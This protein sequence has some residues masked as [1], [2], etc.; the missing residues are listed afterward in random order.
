M[1]AEL[2][3]LKI[4]FD[5]ASTEEV[6]LHCPFHDDKSPSCNVNVKT[7]QFICRAADCAKGREGGD[8]VSL[9]SAI[10][11]VPRIVLLEELGT[12]YD[13]EDVRI[14][15]PKVIERWHDAIWSAKPLLQA[16][17][18]RAVTDEDIKE[19]K[20][21]ENNGRI[22]IPVR[23]DR[24]D[25]VNVRKYLP[26]ASGADKMKNMPGRGQ[27]RWFMPEQ[28]AY[29]SVMICGGEMKAVVAKR[30]LNPH[31][32]GAVSITAGERLITPDLLRRLVGKVCYV[33][34]DI[35]DAG[36]AAAQLNCRS[37]RGQ[38]SEVYDVILPLDRLKYPKGDTNDFV[39]AGGDLWALIDDEALEQWQPKETY[40]GGD[41]AEPADLHITAAA[42]A[43]YAG[44][45]VRVGGVVSMME[46]APFIVP[47]DVIVDCDRSQPFCSLCPVFN[48][49]DGE[50]T[51]GP[52]NPAV[53]EAI[54]ASKYQ[55]REAIMNGIGVP[56]ACRV[57]Q[58]TTKTHYNAEDARLAPQLELTNHA[59]DRSMTPAVCIGE[60]LELNG[61]YQFT[62]RMWPNPRT[63]QSTLL[64][65]SYSPTKDSLST[66]VAR[67]LDRLVMFRPEE[68]SVE[69]VSARLDRLYDDIENNVTRVRQRRTLHLAVDLAYHSPLH[70]S[71]DDRII[72]GWTEVLIL[73]DTSQ[74]KSE[75][76]CG[77]GRPG[78]LLMHY[79]IGEK[80]ECKNATAAGLLG[81]VQSSGGKF[82]VSWGA[83]VAHDRRLLILDEFNGISVEGIAKLTDMRSS[84]VAELPKIERRKAL[85]R[86]RIVAIANSRS[87]RPMSAFPFGIDALMELMGSPQDLRRFDLAMI[88]AADE[89]DST[90]INR[91][92]EEWPEIEHVHTT[93]LCRSLI[94]WAWTRRPEQATFHREAV[95]AT[96]DGTNRLCE[97]YSDDVPLVDRGSTRHKLARLSAA[98]A[99]R[100]FSTTDDMESVLVRPCHVQYIEQLIDSEYSKPSVGYA[101]Y[102]QAV[103]ATTSIVNIEQIIA[104]LAALPYPRETVT[105]MLRTERIE[106]QDVQDWSGWDA[107]EA[108]NLMSLLVRSHALIRDGRHYK[109]SGEFIGLLKH[110]LENG[111]LE[112]PKHVKPAPEE[113]F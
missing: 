28:L 10:L 101:R 64:I 58:T 40:V 75:V 55:L 48:K 90:V 56:L 74:G 45:R 52:E 69:G 17:Y 19:L 76:A 70:L 66:Y 35:D 11:R 12:R 33:Q 22:M 25:V 50:F 27:A 86:C 34:M 105:S 30:Q 113:K 14:V 81:G 44:R 100:T 84:G 79:G 99:A 94:L 97:K 6:K 68:W 16:L 98:L 89:V 29:E 36:R 59:S 53:L 60:G 87:R 46:T 109:K 42:N 72:K 82:F 15:D 88:L 47:K 57:C 49:A 103:K 43:R 78:G 2:E 61:A 83:W 37:L 39:K 112:K 54:S 63:Q 110:A 85:A 92:R 104:N 67:D 106:P 8:F 5:W 1:L 108:K 95:K 26:G 32:V 21:G 102:S 96:Y 77:S 62:G 65:S 7:G 107:V 18:D 38:A 24:G 23:N 51:I 31:G 80:I 4:E 91:R 73:G 71:F 111:C 20:L 41:D 3:R 13:L 93:E 9:L